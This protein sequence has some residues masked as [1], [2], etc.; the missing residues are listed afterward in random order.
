MSVPK[1]NDISV[2]EYH[3]IRR[4]GNRNRKKKWCLK[5]TTVSVI[6]NYLSV[7]KKGTDKRMKKIA[8]SQ[9]LYKIQIICT[10]QNS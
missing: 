10:M 6:M 7:I 8:G 3:K 9:S 4:S 5:I 2:K 1:D